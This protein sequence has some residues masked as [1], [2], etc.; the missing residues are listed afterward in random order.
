MS[1]G[2]EA[3]AVGVQHKK[4]ERHRRQIETEGVEHPGGQQQQGAG[5]GHEEP[6][7]ASGDPSRRDV[8]LGGA[9]ILLVDGGVDDAVEPH[10]RAA[11]AN[12]GHA[13]PENLSEGRRLAAGQ[14]CQHHPHQCEGKGENG[15]GK[16]NHLQQSPDF[17]QQ[18]GRAHRFASSSMCD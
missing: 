12:H 7:F 16:F 4:T 11:G 18:R 14:G 15:V 3:L 6:G 13:D 1:Q 9:G 8:P 5:A 10:G 17:I 2:G